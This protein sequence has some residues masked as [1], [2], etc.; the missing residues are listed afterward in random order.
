[1]LAVRLDEEWLLL[2][3]LTLILVRAPEATHYHFHLALALDMRRCDSG[4]CCR[5]KQQL[6][7]RWPAAAEWSR[8]S[9]S[10]RV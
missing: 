5:L 3:N 4:S 2:D 1:M 10:E 7:V 8:R 6:G 9:S